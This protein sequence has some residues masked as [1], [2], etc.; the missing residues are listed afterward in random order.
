[1]LSPQIPVDGRHQW[2]AGVPSPPGTRGSHAGLP[3]VPW[4]TGTHA[5]LL[6]KRA[7]LSHVHV[8][9]L[10]SSGPS[11]RAFVSLVCEGRKF[12]GLEGIRHRAGELAEGGPLPRSMARVLSASPRGLTPVPPGPWKLPEHFRGREALPGGRS[13]PPTILTSLQGA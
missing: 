11:S 8:S 12:K 7:A 9:T 10:V 6:C 4:P 1:M 3:W 2:Q 13:R 5:S